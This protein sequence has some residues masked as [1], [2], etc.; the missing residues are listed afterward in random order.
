MKQIRHRGVLPCRLHHQQFAQWYVQ[1]IFLGFL[2][3]PVDA[4]GTDEPCTLTGSPLAL[5][6][7]KLQLFGRDLLTAVA[8]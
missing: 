3:G 1:V 5:L 2:K 7:K 8:Q 4:L 6:T